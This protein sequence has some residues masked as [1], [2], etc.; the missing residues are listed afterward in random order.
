MRHSPHKKKSGNS[1]P[2]ELESRG[3]GELMLN[4]IDRDGKR[5]GYDLDLLK[6]ISSS[7]GIPVIASCGSHNL[8]D[9]TKAK[10]AGALA[11]SAG[12]Q[13]VYYGTNNAVLVSIP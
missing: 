11:A 6:A 1:S 2:K 9:F 4:C 10:E 5:N 8:D 7:V 13:F 12:S 3:I